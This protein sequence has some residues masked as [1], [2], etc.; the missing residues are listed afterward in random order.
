M[1]ITASLQ[2]K[3]NIY[4]VVLNVFLTA[5][6]DSAIGGVFDSNFIDFLHNFVVY[7]YPVSFFFIIFPNII[8]KMITETVIKNSCS[9]IFPPL[10]SF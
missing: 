10:N 5:L 3:N 6:N 2:I 9:N 7:L 4:Q 1:N 8:P